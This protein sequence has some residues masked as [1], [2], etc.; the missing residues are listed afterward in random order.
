MSEP[1]AQTALAGVAPAA[2]P[3]IIVASVCVPGGSA[4]TIDEKKIAASGW[5][6][7]VVTSWFPVAPGSVRMPVAMFV[8]S[9]PRRAR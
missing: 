9:E 8:R 6:D 7:R 1:P 3:I 5:N 2:A 4:L